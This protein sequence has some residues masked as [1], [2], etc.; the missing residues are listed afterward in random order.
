MSGMVVSLSDH[1]LSHPDNA[2]TEQVG[3]SPT[4]PISRS[5]SAKVCSSG[6]SYMPGSA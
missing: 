1:G 5:P 4:R 2:E 3:F 6:R